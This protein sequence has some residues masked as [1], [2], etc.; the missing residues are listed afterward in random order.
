MKV[1]FLC[2]YNE[3]KNTDYRKKK[4]TKVIGKGMIEDRKAKKKEEKKTLEFPKLQK[5]KKKKKKE[6]LG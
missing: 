2:R 3:N 4:Y 5:K 6:G 1:R